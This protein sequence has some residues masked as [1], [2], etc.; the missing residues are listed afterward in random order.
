MRIRDQIANEAFEHCSG[1]CDVSDENIL[2]E[3]DSNEAV[4][5]TIRQ[6][7]DVV[8]VV[9]GAESARKIDQYLSQDVE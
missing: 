2:D 5:Y 6:L 9:H 3:H 8:A 4:E 7:L 1:P